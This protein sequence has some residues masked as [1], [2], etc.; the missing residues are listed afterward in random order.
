MYTINLY[1]RSSDDYPPTPTF[2]SGSAQIHVSIPDRQLHESGLDLLTYV[3]DRMKETIKRRIAGKSHSI[4]SSFF[5]LDNVIIDIPCAATDVVVPRRA[6]APSTAVEG[7][8]HS[9]KSMSLL[10]PSR[11]RQE[12]VQ[13]CLMMKKS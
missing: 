1:S 6:P 12:L 2:L 3:H 13:P 11:V 4:H 5:S 7:I 8:L 10:F 9:L